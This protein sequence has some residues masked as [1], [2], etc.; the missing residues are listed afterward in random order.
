VR[1]YC[2]DV[3]EDGVGGD[4]F[5]YVHRLRE[6]VNRQSHALKVAKLAGLPDEAISIAKGVLEKG[7]GSV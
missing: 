2:T 1:F 6:G 7:L 3:Q 5:R 4:G